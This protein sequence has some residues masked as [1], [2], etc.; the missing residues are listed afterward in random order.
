M[1]SDS[2]MRLDPY[3]IDD[4]IYFENKTDGVTTGLRHLGACITAMEKTSYD[5][6][7]HVLKGSLSIILKNG[8]KEIF[9]AGQTFVIPKG[10]TCRREQSSNTKTYY[11]T[12]EDEG[13]LPHYNVEDLGVI[14]LDPSDTIEEIPIADTSQFQGLIP[15]H[16]KHDYY[17]DT[18]GRFLVA[19]WN[20]D[21]FE[22][23]VAPFNRYE[24]MIFLKGSVN[25][26]DN[27]TISEN[28]NA[29][30]AAFVPH[31]A[32]YK[33]K[34]EEYLSKYYCIVMPK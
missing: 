23:A 28:F 26:S 5:E 6:F 25:L 22:R 8:R 34:S 3:A 21:P 13:S 16:Y 12:F 33:W 7:V 30:Q 19:M 15:K 9:G 17:S 32:P 27:N 10:L 18:T 29:H 4:K 20:S 1:N 11:M 14:R 31:L 2:I 24:L